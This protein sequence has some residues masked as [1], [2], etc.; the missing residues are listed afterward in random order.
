ME[1]GVGCATA[2][3]QDR[4]A[5]RASEGFLLPRWRVGL[6]ETAGAQVSVI[7]PRKRHAQGKLH[8][9]MTYLPSRSHDHRPLTSFRIE[10][11]NSWMP[12]PPSAVNSRIQ[13]ISGRK[14]NSAA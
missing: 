2:A 6:P 3:A 14:P 9:L 7:S 11:G 4:E 12:S 8:Q 1:W 10:S 13:I 5:R